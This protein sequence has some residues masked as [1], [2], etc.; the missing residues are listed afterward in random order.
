MNILFITYFN[1]AIRAAACCP[2]RWYIT[3]VWDLTLY[4]SWR[5]YFPNWK[6]CHCQISSL[7]NWNVRGN[8]QV[9]S[10]EK[11]I[12][13]MHLIPL[14]PG[15]WNEFLEEEIH[16]RMAVSFSELWWKV[17]KAAVTLRLSPN[18]TMSQGWLWL[19]VDLICWDIATSPSRRR[20]RCWGTGIL[21]L[22]W[23]NDVHS[24][25]HVRDPFRPLKTEN[26]VIFLFLKKKTAQN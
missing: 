26:Y 11:E 16:Q 24:N 15:A 12:L 2:K 6:H 9:W 10:K 17:R 23:A 18:V 20:C 8:R 21:S 4:S 22:E 1:I 5:I 25:R 13:T 14:V 7:S 19:T 3:T